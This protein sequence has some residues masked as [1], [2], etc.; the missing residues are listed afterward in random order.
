[1][2]ETTELQATKKGLLGYLA[3]VQDGRRRQG[4]KYAL[5]SLLGMLL[6]GAINGEQSLRGMWMW[7][8]AHWE[9]IREPL[10]FPGG[11]ERKPQYGTVWNALAKVSL[12][13]VVDTLQQWWADRGM[14]EE[15]LSVDGKMLRGSKRRPDKGGIEMVA[16]ALQEAGVVIAETMVEAGGSI[17]AALK[18]LKGLPLKDKVV[19]VDAGLHQR[20]L[21]QCVVEKGGGCLGQMKNNHGEVKDAIAVVLEEAAKRH[22]PAV[23]Q[24]EKGHGRIE[25]REYWWV[26][27]DEAL[28]TYLASEYGWADVRWCGVVRR[29]WR[30]L[31]ESAWH[32]EQRL[33]TFSAGQGF[34]KVTPQ[35]LSM[36]ARR[37]WHIENRTFWVLDVTYQEDQNHARRV[38]SM[39]HMIR[40]M[41]INVIRRQ[42]FRYIPD[43]RR[44]ATARPDR[45]LAWLRAQ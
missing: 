36:W 17:E 13:E 16:A 27:V 5:V 30:H 42:G 21:A 18:L 28:R 9:N 25:R 22:P 31:Y 15:A 2:R 3:Q 35:A 1:M 43:G 32:E 11:D 40:N 37:H 19:T 44:T 7:G 33:W 41:A 4:R 10:G 14:E 24:S 29:R 23:V 8:Q 45:G 34:P 6:L 12:E 39:L 38:G 26:K 20:R